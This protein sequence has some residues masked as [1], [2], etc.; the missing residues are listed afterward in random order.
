VAFEANILTAVDHYA[1]SEI[2]SREWHNEYFDFI[3]D[4]ALRDR[5]GEEFYSARYIYKVLQG[6]SVQSELQVAQVRLQV[7][8]YASIYEAVLHHLLFDLLSNEPEVRELLSY[9]SLKKYSVPPEKRG[10]SPIC[11]S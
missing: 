1:K 9:E 8:Q 2:R 11:C 7:L 5:L 6:L 10:Y 3:R 4:P